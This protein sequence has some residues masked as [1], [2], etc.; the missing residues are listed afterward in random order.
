MI[1]LKEL[2]TITVWLEI[3]SKVWDEAH[4]L[5][6]K[7]KQSGLNCPMADVLI[8]AC[9][10]RYDADLIYRDRHFDRLRKL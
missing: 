1:A 7:A 4:V 10:N 8:N 2:R 9:A 3:D 6:Q 5:G